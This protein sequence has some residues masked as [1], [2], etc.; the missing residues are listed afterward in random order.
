MTDLVN[1][2]LSEL[3]KKIKNKEISSKELTNSYIKRAK[4]SK[5]LNVYIQDNFNSALKLSEKF[6][7]SPDF[8]KKIARNTYGC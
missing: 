1:F 4:S 6:D 7:S 8:E 2:T 5:H 3:V